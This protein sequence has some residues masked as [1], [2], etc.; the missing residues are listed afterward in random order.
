MPGDGGDGGDGG[1][2]DGE[3]DTYVYMYVNQV[4]GCG[5]ARVCGVHWGSLE[6]LGSAAGTDD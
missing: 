6:S 2:G 3:P 4:C 1:E 5:V